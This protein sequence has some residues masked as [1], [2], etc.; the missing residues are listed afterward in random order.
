MK[1]TDITKL[2]LE[3]AAASLICLPR[4]QWSQWLGYLLEA[5]DYNGKLDD[6]LE[7][8]ALSIQGRLENGRW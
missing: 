4:E 1:R 8:V 3:Q 7:Q 5:L 6:I 2:R